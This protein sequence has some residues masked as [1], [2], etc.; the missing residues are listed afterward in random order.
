[1]VTFESDE[2]INSGAIFFFF[3]AVSVGSSVILLL[4]K[5]SVTSI[6]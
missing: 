4:Q 6:Q 5:K 1:M 3:D 2:N